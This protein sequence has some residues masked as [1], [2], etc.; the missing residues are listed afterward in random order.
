M[1]LRVLMS[2][3]KERIRQLE[4]EKNVDEARL[5]RVMNVSKNLFRIY[6]S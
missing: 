4:K 6:W 5:R 2:Q 3:V 1:E